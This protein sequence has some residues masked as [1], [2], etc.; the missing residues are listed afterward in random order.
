MSFDPSFDPT[1][2]PENSGNPPRPPA[3]TF[4]QEVQHSSATAR[5]PDHIGAGVFATGAI[6]MHGMHEFV[7]D[8]IQSLS[9]PKR[10]VARVALPPT[11][12]P[13][14]VAALQDNI[15]KYRQNVGPLQRPPMP[16]ATPPAPI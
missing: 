4:H 5:V 2:G 13:L 1:N 11:V 7:I 10:I 16:G 15:A 3:P 6:V 14:F 9:S 8:F 12:V